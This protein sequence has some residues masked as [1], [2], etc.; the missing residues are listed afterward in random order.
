MAFITNMIPEQAEV[1]DRAD[2]L[3]SLCKKA[4][5]DCNNVKS[6]LDSL[7]KLRYKQRNSKVNK[8]QLK[9]LYTQA[10]SEAE[11]QK[12]TLMAA[13]EKVSEIRT[14]EY[15]LRTHVGPK[16]FRRGVLMSVL[17]ENAKSI[18]LWIGKS[19]ESPPP[20]CGAIGP[21][22][23]VPADPGDHVA[24]LVPEP[25]VVAAA[26]NLSEGCILAEVVSYNP[27]K[28]IYEVEDVDA[29]E[30]KMR[31]SLCRSKVIP[32]PKWKAN[33]ITNP[34]AIFKKGVTVLAL[35]PQTTCFYKA[36]VD[37][38]PTHVHDEYSLYFEDSSYP[39]GYAPAIRIPQ[40]YVIHCPDK[41]AMTS[42]HLERSKRRSK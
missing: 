29:E 34:E 18:P 12:A 31:Y 38:I 30:G 20:L 6:T 1:K 39:E 37:E 24:A 3:L 17:Q 14:L 26:C 33:P 5:A 13:L 41:E 11:Q 27:E 32:L 8:N 10:I 40:R 4:V 9:S 21:S 35:Y 22:P 2:E 28:E 15:K 7:D 23:N 42:K 16:S 25:D 36:I 19:A